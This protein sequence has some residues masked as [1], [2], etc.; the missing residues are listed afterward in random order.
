MYRVVYS[1]L[2]RQQIAD[3]VAYLRSEGVF[4]ETIEAWFAGL[5]DR[6]DDLAQYP[7]RHAAAEE[8]TPIAGRQVRRLVYGRYLI[9][10][11]VNEA[12]RMVEV[13]AFQHGGRSDTE[14]R[15]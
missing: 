15:P 1:S 7:F 5:F 3:Q 13:I 2:A 9:F 14:E 6:V 4:D 10:Y 11:S 12:G 8:Y